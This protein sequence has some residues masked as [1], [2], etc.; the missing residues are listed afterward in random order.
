MNPTIEHYCLL[1]E[2]TRESWGHVIYTQTEIV[3]FTFPNGDTVLMPLYDLAEISDQAVAQLVSE[4]TVCPGC[5][6]WHAPTDIARIVGASG[7]NYAICSCDDA[8]VYFGMAW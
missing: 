4:D 8:K 5:L 2:P 1:Q 7:G 3:P 6:Q